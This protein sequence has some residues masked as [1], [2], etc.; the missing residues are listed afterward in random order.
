[1]NLEVCEPLHKLTSVK[2]DWIWNK[3][4][5]DLYEKA[6]TIVKRDIGMKFYNAARSLYL[7]TDTSRIGIGAGLLLVRD[8][9][10]CRFDKIPDNAIL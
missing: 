4:Y 7:E 2:A 3:R 10:N 8:G 9:M 5:Q 1:M 6:K